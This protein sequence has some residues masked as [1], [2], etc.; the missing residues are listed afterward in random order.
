VLRSESLDETLAAEFSRI[1]NGFANHPECQLRAVFNWS[2]VTTSRDRALTNDELKALLARANTSAEDLNNVLCV[3]CRLI[4]INSLPVE[5]ARQC[6]EWIS[7][8]AQP[9]LSSEAKYHVIA[10]ANRLHND[11]QDATAEAAH[12][13]QAVQPVA[14]EDAGTWDRIGD[15]LCDVLKHKP[16]DLATIFMNL[17]VASAST[18]HGLL[19]TRRMRHLMHELGNA[20]V[21]VLIGKLALAVDTPTRKL[22]I[23]LFDELDVKELPDG[24]LES[25]ESIAPRL[26]FYEIQRTILKPSTIARVL[27]ALVPNAEKAPEA[28]REEFFDELKLQCHNFSGCRKELQTLAKEKTLVAKALQEVTSYFDALTRAHDAGINAMEVAGHR[29]AARQQRR[30]FNKQVSDGARR[31]SPLLSMMKHVSLLYGQAASQFID[32]QLRDARPLAHMST[33]MELPMVDF[34]DPEEMALRRIH[35]SA[36][37]SRL[38]K[39]HYGGREVQDEC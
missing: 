12:W 14:K 34:F 22:G 35:A 20:D 38:L 19:T 15:F 23:F 5:L 4:A 16:D 30:L 21:S 33:S 13:I 1:E 2:W 8:A 25:C 3:V 18:I 24:V 10:A 29:A 28:F 17:C 27:A 11:N 32:G 9:P 37:I 31:G 26:L 39:Q 36:A 7:T 6:R